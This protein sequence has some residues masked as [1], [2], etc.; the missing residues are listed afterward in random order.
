MTF[1]EF[2]VILFHFFIVIAYF[3]Y[4]LGNKNDQMIDSLKDDVEFY[5]NWVTNIYT[6]EEDTE[7][8]GDEYEEDDEEAEDVQNDENDEEVNEDEEDQD[9]IEEEEEEDKKYNENDLYVFVKELTSTK[10]TLLDSLDSV[11]HSLCLL[12]KAVE[13]LQEEES[14]ED[15]N[16]EQKEEKKTEEVTTTSTDVRDDSVPMTDSENVEEIVEEKSA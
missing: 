10:K 12:M 5:R 11:N 9:E 3:T 16:E 15:N 2:Y 1:D 4:L 14:E 8:C 7:E 6:Y 13:R